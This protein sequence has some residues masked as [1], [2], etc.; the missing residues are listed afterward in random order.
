MACTKKKASG[1]FHRTASLDPTVEE[2]LKILEV[3][4]NGRAWRSRG[5]P[6]MMAVDVEAIVARL[7]ELLEPAG[8]TCGYYPPPSQEVPPPPYFVSFHIHIPRTRR[9]GKNGCTWLCAPALCAPAHRIPDGRPCAARGPFF[10]QSA[11]GTR[12]CIIRKGW[13]I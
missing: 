10:S 6:A 4:L 11:E 7:K 12:F 1:M 3:A 13:Y 2:I 9:Y 8:I 5:K